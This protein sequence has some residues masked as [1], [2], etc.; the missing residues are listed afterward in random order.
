MHFSSCHA[1]V[2]HRQLLYKT[3]NV[4]T[5]PWC[6]PYHSHARDDVTSWSETEGLISSGIEDLCYSTNLSL[7]VVN[8]LDVINALFTTNP[9]WI[10]FKS[11]T[12]D[13]Y[14]VVD[15]N[16]W[17]FSTSCSRDDVNEFPYR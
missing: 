5:L 3:N 1:C 14:K 13:C 6:R 10:F 16:V 9:A 4:T 15:D 11:A 17:Y 7:L 2:Q 8:K 12:C